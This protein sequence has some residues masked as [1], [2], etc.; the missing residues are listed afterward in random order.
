LQPLSA[1]VMKMQRE[2]RDSFAVVLKRLALA[3]EDVVLLRTKIAG[4][5]KGG[6]TRTQVPTVE[7]VTKTIEKMTA[8]VT[9]KSGD[10]DVLENSLKKLNLKERSGT[11]G[12]GASIRARGMR[13][14][15]PFATPPRDS[16]ALVVGGSKGGAGRTY[17]LFDTPDG[18]PN[19]KGREPEVDREVVRVF[20]E[21]RATRKKLGQLLAKA[22]L[23]KGTRVTGMGT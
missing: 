3:E 14:A 10:I 17:G 8:M 12:A 22:V 7:A 15:S 11:P 16:R 13:E 2:L 20:N 4:A 9:K 21:K 18:T 19:G 6:R 23:E 1:E 5:G